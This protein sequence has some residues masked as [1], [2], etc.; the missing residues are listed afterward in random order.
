MT[1][2]EQLPEVTSTV[3]GSAVAGNS[4][5][6]DEE[7]TD[8]LSE[9]IRLADGT[10]VGWASG[11]AGI[12]TWTQGLAA[13]AKITVL[14][15]KGATIGTG[16]IGRSEAKNVGPNSRDEW[17]CSF[18]FS[19]T[20]RGPVPES[21]RIRVAALPAM[22]ARRDPDQPS[23]FVASVSTVADPKLIESCGQLPAAEISLWSPA[24]GEYWSDGFNQICFAGVAIAKVERTCR[25]R[26]IGSDR[27]VAVLS[28]KNPATVYE[29]ATGMKIDDVT[30]LGAQPKVLVRVSN[31]QPCP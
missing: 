7:G 25:P 30:S 29:D 17:V 4:G 14:D 19:A 21:F 11:R 12:G 24:V 3:A 28:A 15:A 27:V 26:T 10:C 22:V 23:L 9:V 31:G 8:E 6:I 20:I 16:R 2:E 13:G 18:S 5:G 1:S